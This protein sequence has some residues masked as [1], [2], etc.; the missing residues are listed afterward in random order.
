[1]GLRRDDSSVDS[2]VD[3]EYFPN[4]HDSSPKTTKSH[5]SPS[6]LSRD[7]GLTLS[8]TQLYDEDVCPHHDM[9]N[10]HRSSSQYETQEPDAH[11]GGY[12]S[13]S[14]DNR[15]DRRHNPVAPPRKK[16]TKKSADGNGA[17][18]D[19]QGYNMS[20]NYRPP[21]KHSSSTT[22]LDLNNQRRGDLRPMLTHPPFAKRISSDSI[23]E[24]EESPH[25]SID[26]QRMRKPSDIGTLVK[27][28]SGTHLFLGDEMLP[29]KYTLGQATGKVQG[30]DKFMHQS[31]LSDSTPPMS[32]M[33]RY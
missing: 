9:R 8:D 32:P 3:R 6:N 25:S 11:E 19:S 23:G 33:S 2:L 21:F 20:P 17:Y 30:K 26:F 31:S 4:E 10:F 29:T 22:Q 14:A 16:A 28:E 7:S 18:E 12:Y 27:S 5:L 24:E 15:F 13:R 1:M